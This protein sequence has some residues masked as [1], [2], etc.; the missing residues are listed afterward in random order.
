MKLNNNHFIL[1]NGE[2]R[3]AVYHQTAQKWYFS[4]P[5]SLNFPVIPPKFLPATS[6]L[7]F[8]PSHDLSITLKADMED[9]EI[10]YRAYYENTPV[11]EYREYTAPFSMPLRSDLD[12]LVDAYTVLDGVPSSDGH[13]RYSSIPDIPKITLP[14][15]SHSSPALT[16]HY[17]RSL[18]LKAEPRYNTETWYCYNRSEPDTND[19][20]MKDG[21][22]TI[23]DYGVSQEQPITFCAR[24]S[25]LLGSN[26]Y[27]KWSNS[28]Y[29]YVKKVSTIPQPVVTLK[30]DGEEIEAPDPGSTI[31]F[32][33]SVT[34]T[35]KKSSDWPLDVVPGSKT[36]SSA[37]SSSASR[38][39]MNT[40]NCEFKSAVVDSSGEYT[41]YSDPIT[42]KFQKIA[43][44]KLWLRDC[45]AT[46]DEEQV[47]DNDLVAAGSTVT[48][49]PTIPDG[50]TFKGWYSTDNI[51][52]TDHGDG[53]YSFTMP[54]EPITI[55]AILYAQ[56]YDS[57][58]VILTTP[59]DNAS[60]DK[61]T[62]KVTP[63]QITAELQWYKGSEPYHGSFVSTE[64]CYRIHIICHAAE[65]AI[66]SGGATIKV[67]R[68]PGKGRPVTKGF[69]LSADKKTL[70]FDAWLVY[71]PEI[72]IP[73]HEGETPPTA[74][75]CILPP[76]LTVETLTWNTDG[77]IN[78]LRIKDP[79]YTF[80]D[81]IC[82]F[83]F[84]EGWATINGKRYQGEFAKRIPSGDDTSQLIFK[85][86]TIPNV[87]KGV[88]VSGTAVSW[89][90][91]DNAEYRL[92]DGSTSDADIKADM[93]LASPVKALAYTAT[94]GGITA[95]A[96][97]KRYDQTFSF[98]TVPAGTY[99]LAIFK[100]GKYV[101]KIV[102]ITIDSTDYT[103]GQ[104]KLW[105]YGDVNYDGK[106]SIIDAVQI[107]MYKAGKTSVFTDGSGQDIADRMVAANVTEVTVGDTI[108][109]VLDAVQ[110][111]LYKAGKSSAF[112]SMK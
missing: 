49:K 34:A 16:Y 74:N 95:N 29:F 1:K 99:K 78:E 17:Y 77:T 6:F 93:K 63:A 80:G 57:V 82:A 106:V 15:G 36:D 54:D 84:G 45:T 11:P 33:D 53:T 62:C 91:T 81:T 10:W 97:G 73:L 40:S 65:G 101:P 3:M 66:F 32:N 12:I 59:S 52:I 86:I 42:Y 96:D 75:D 9:T 88:S 100:P 98:S 48:I 90:N 24:K 68:F 92:Y 56:E 64:A 31:Y 4:K 39:V 69:T 111:Q 20:I 79:H 30:V 35:I 44:N 41:E 18:W 14:D 70:E 102:P 67:N 38:T 22:L 50:Y 7:D 23:T 103:C 72:T 21:K 87:P 25:F 47:Q 58:E 19:S 60:V 8:S 71:A 85:S 51:P 110:I 37:F 112:D 61:A 26:T 27:F 83:S 76:G 109:N 105:L 107:Q 55:R 104:L 89:S 28:Q 108:V 43:R 2:Y 5:I 46:V 94:K 13:A